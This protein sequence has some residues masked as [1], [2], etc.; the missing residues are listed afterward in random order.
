MPKNTVISFVDACIDL[1][2]NNWMA[3]AGDYHGNSNWLTKPLSQMTCVPHTYTL[4]TLI[5]VVDLIQICY[6][7]LYDWIT[8]NGNTSKP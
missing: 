8:Y 5:F 6:L 4:I 3:I 7:A 2:L 1:D